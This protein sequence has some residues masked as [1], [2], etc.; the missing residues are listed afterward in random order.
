MYTSEK[1]GNDNFGDGTESKLFKMILQTMKYAG[2][3][4]FLLIYVDYKTEGEKFEPAPKTQLKKN[5]K[6]L[7]WK[8]S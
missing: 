3:E 1:F 2:R 8:N 4:L 7:G 5:L 6:F